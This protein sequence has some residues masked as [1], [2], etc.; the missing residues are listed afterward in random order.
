[1]NLLTGRSA[2]RRLGG[3]TLAEAARLAREAA[4]SRPKEQAWGTLTIRRSAN[5]HDPHRR[6]Q[7]VEW[8]R[9][10]ADLIENES[11]SLS[12]QYRARLL[13]GKAPS[14]EA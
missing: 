13:P 6:A 4:K 11:E 8:L 10:N 14:R 5:L 12:A 3:M 2:A 1:M 7:I 9:R